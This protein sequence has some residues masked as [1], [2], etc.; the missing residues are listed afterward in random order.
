MLAAWERLEERVRA[1]QVQAV[2]LELHG[3]AMDAPDVPEI[4]NPPDEVE[5]AERISIMVESGTPE[6]EAERLARIEFGLPPR[7]S[8]PRRDGARAQLAGTA[9]SPAFDAEGRATVGCEKKCRGG[10]ENANSVRDRGRNREA[11]DH[12]R[13]L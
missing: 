7:D 10:Y 12:Q 3:D 5:L 9:S 11:G 4:A 2:E 8:P 6:P 1:P 13:Q